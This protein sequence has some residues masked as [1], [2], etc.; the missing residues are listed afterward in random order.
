MFLGLINFTARSPH[1]FCLLYKDLIENQNSI[2]LSNEAS[3]EFW[4][5]TYKPS[6]LPKTNHKQKG[7]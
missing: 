6:A 4:E 2:D 3:S 5:K 7:T 1:L